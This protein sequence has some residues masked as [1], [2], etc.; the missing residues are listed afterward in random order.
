MTKVVGLV[1]HQDGTVPASATVEVHNSVGD[2][3]D[4]IRV[5][6]EGSFIYYLSPGKWT[7]MTYDGRGHRGNHEV[8]LDEEDGT[9]S[10]H[11]AIN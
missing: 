9:I 8:A 3:V 11:L 2:V 5:T 7:F 6:D 10:I 4:Q 1:R